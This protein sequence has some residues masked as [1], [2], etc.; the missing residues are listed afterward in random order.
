MFDAKE[1]K[2]IERLAHISLTQAA[3]DAYREEVKE[4]LE[5][6]RAHV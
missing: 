6:G 1:L 2:K 3:I 4:N 5:I